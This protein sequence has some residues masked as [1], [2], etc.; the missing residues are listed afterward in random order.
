[1]KCQMV[2]QMENQMPEILYLSPAQQRKQIQPD[3]EPLHTPYKKG[4]KGEEKV[5]KVFSLYN[6]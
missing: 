1:M 4:R 2:A 6:L 5:A 3:T